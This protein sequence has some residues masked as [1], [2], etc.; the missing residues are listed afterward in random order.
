MELEQIP[1]R[2]IAVG[3]FLSVCMA[4]MMIFAYKLLRP[5]VKPVAGPQI[6]P[7]ASK[8]IDVPKI[9]IDGPKK[10]QV[11]DKGKLAKK[12]ALP[13]ELKDSPHEQPT[14]TADIKP[15]AYGGTAVSFTNMSTGKSVIS[16]QAKPRPWFEFGGQTAIGG[17]I[18]ISSK[19]GQVGALRVR[20]D[21]LRLWGAQ[22][23]AEGEANYHPVTR[24]SEARAMVWGEHRF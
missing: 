22:L 13:P 12:I 1:W 21:V 7:E 10:L 5:S 15:S 6:A 16:Y 9:V 2:K 4:A 19:G 23:S 11:Y 8:A 18:G 14:A 24:E 17:G 20:Q 3:A